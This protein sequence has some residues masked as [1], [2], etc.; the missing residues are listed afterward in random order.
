M[1]AQSGRLRLQN[2]V[3]CSIFTPFLP[4]LFFCVPPLY[5][6]PFLAIFERGV[7]KTVG[8]LSS[9]RHTTITPGGGVTRPAP[10]AV[11]FCRQA[12]HKK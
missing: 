12:L 1:A 7:R 10:W 8:G 3:F 4:P 11:I 5:L 6:T 9:A 2:P